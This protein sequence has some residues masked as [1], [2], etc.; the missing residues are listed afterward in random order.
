MKKQPVRIL[1]ALLG[2]TMTLWASSPIGV[3]EEVVGA[4]TAE[5]QQNTIRTLQPGDEVYL[6]DTIKTGP[7]SK[8]LIRFVDNTVV[9]QGEQGVLHLDE[10]V[11]N[12]SEPQENGSTLR[13]LKG[14]FRILTDQI[15]KLNP[16]RFVVET[17]EGTIGIRGCEVGLDLTGDLRVFV[18]SLADVDSVVVRSREEPSLGRTAEEV[19]IRETGVGATLS[20]KAGISLFTFDADDLETLY[21][22][23]TPGWT[24]EDAETPAED[25]GEST[26]E[27]SEET[28][29][30]QIEEKAQEAQSNLGADQLVEEVTEQ[31]TETETRE[32]ARARPVE[33]SRPS[34]KTVTTTT[35]LATGS[36]ADWSWGLWQDEAITTQPDGT[37]TRS[38]SSDVR[39]SG[40]MLSSAEYQELLLS[41]PTLLTHAS[42]SGGAVIQSGS[43]VSVVTGSAG[44]DVTVG[45]VV[46]SWLASFNLTGGSDSLVFT[47]SGGFTPSGSMQGGVD[48]YTLNAFSQTYGIPSN[49]SIDGN[50]IKSPGAV[51]PIVPADISGSVLEFQFDHSGGPSVKGAG[52]SDY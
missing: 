20:K 9:A 26:S 36:G 23:T 37:V 15:T 48:S 40:D 25:E 3:A 17:Q 7:D 43:D 32:P 28:D 24:Q 46:N 51:S 30:S 1:I 11:Y 34:S 22:M 35:S 14:L 38:L 29:T 42:S 41:P 6:L 33:D 5:S 19:V 52:G 4:V 45:S 47:A 49:Q 12:P 27:E 18:I 39:L 21:R 10:Y 50:L 8:A 2:T 16:D 13:I 31:P 44:I